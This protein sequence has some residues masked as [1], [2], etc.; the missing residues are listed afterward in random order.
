MSEE[1]Y[2]DRW[3]KRDPIERSIL[4]KPWKYNQ[5]VA[6]IEVYI[7]NNDIRFEIFKTDKSRHRYDSI[8]KTYSYFSSGANHFFIR[9]DDTNKIIKEQVIRY[10]KRI[11]RELFKTTHTYIDTECFDNQF[12]LIDIRSLFF[13]D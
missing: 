6:Y 3:N 8:Y 5:I 13:R 9:K 11:Q 7:D 2:D 12:E 10:V 1:E 4:K